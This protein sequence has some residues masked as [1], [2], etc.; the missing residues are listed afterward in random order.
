VR[1]YLC[2]FVC[3]CLYL[4]ACVDVSAHMCASVYF[5]FQLLRP[6]SFKIYAFE[7]TVWLLLLHA[8]HLSKSLCTCSSCGVVHKTLSS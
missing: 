2:V 6:A 3:E 7:A 5:S 8:A 1:V 4:C